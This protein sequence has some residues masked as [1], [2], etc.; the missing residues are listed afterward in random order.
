MNVNI[1]RESEAETGQYWASQTL[2]DALSTLAEKRAKATV[3]FDYCRDAEIKARAILIQHIESAAARAFGQA[4]LKQVDIPYGDW[5]QTCDDLFI[6]R[7]SLETIR[8]TEKL[9]ELVGPALS[10]PLPFLVDLDGRA[11]KN[12]LRE[13]MHAM[14]GHSG[15]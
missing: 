12:V 9:A 13:F 15:R 11:R 2:K 1:E 6:A 10:S 14:T 4:P 3:R 8:A 7:G 5:L